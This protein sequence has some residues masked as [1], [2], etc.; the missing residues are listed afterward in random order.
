[1]SSA[2]NWPVREVTRIGRRLAMVA[3]S[4]LASTATAAQPP[5]TPLAGA[6][7]Q[8]SKGQKPFTVK[9]SIEMV[10]F[11]EPWENAGRPHPQFSPE[12]DKFFIV[13]EKGNLK[14]NL[15]EYT[16]I[17]YT[18]KALDRPVRVATFRSSSNRK[19][20][21]QPRW[22]TNDSVSLIGE[23]PR[24]LPQAY[25][26]NCRTRTVRKLTSASSGIVAFDLTRDLKTIIYSARWDGDRRQIEYKDAHGFAIGTEDVFDLS[27]GEIGRASCRER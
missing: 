21:A 2:H 26:V 17:V 3:M 15:R 10:H 5:S 7:T 27:S 8:S 13:T 22:V 19:G 16:L 18:V 9:D 23:N 11:V 6:D 4:L 24:E 20:I 12:G 1:M 25:V 14:T